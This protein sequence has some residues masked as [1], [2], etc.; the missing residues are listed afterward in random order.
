MQ[1]PFQAEI[2]LAGQGPPGGLVGDLAGEGRY[3]PPPNYV[4]ISPRPQSVHTSWLT[5]TVPGDTFRQLV[6]SEGSGNGSVG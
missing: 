1:I 2:F 5:E 6:R 4:E 3:L